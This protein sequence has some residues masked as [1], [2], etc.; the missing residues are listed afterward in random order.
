MDVG[1]GTWWDQ[2]IKDSLEQ[3]S[4]WD[5]MTC[6]YADP[7]KKAKSLDPL[8]T[9]IDYM[10]NCG[11]F[12]MMK[13]S[14]FDLCHFYQVG[15]SGDFQK[16]PKPHEPATSDH[17]CSLLENAHKKGCPNLVVVLSQDAVTAVA[18]LKGLHTSVSFLCLKMETP[19]EAAGKPMQKLSFCPFCQ[20]CGSNYPS[21]LNHII[22]AHYEASFGCGHCLDKVYSSGQVLNKHIARLQGAQDRCDKGEIFSKSC[23]R[24]V[25]EPS[26]QEEAPPP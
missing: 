1:F 16:F 18:L 20:Y 11:I 7:A 22:C 14:K 15:E 6:D 12:K 19:A 3:W 23:E 8:G 24:G 4:K 9:P 5:T 17:V 21:Y 10:E 26:H 25:Q 2:K 13:T